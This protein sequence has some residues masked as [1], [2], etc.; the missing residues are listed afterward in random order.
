MGALPLTSALVVA[1][2]QSCP[3]TDVLGIRERTHIGSNFGNDSSRCSDID[4]GNRAKKIQRF[5]VLQDFL[6]DFILYSMLVRFQI[7][8]MLKH[9]IQ[10]PALVNR[11]RPIQ[12]NKYFV[13]AVS[14][15]GFQTLIQGV[16]VDAAILDK[17]SDD[18]S[19]GR[20]KGVREECS[21]T[22]SGALKEFI[23]PVLLCRNV[24]DNALAV[25]GQMPQLSDALSGIKLPLSNPAL[26]NVAIH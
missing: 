15:F 16:P 2:T 8:Q 20:T 19:A 7:F 1:G 3:G 23:D 17:V 4:S 5:G 9:H 13:N 24:M 12:R 22:E 11:K 18:V 21:E 14:G 25:P 6:S 26:S 10:K